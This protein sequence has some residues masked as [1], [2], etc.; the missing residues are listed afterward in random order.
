M[1]MLRYSRV[2]T[3]TE[4]DV[5]SPFTSFTSAGMGCLQYSCSLTRLS[6]APSRDLRLLDI[7][8]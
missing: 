1:T 3:A 4:R 8:G 2:F 7:C 5:S 6:P